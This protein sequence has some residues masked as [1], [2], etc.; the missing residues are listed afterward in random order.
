MPCVHA[1]MC[2][3][4]LHCFSGH[5]QQEGLKILKLS[6]VLG[7]MG[8]KAEKP[9]SP[10]ALGERTSEKTSG[11]PSLWHQ[12]PTAENL[13]DYWTKHKTGRHWALLA[14]QLVAWFGALP[15]VSLCL[16]CAWNSAVLI[17]W[18]QVCSPLLP[19]SACSTGSGDSCPALSLT[20]Q[21]TFSLSTSVSSS[22]KWGLRPLW[23]TLMSTD[24]VC[25]GI[26]EPSLYFIY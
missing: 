25:C 14:L 1:R 18:G 2:S 22:L 11:T 24:E 20:C 23:D 16:H 5:R 8:N 26:Y 15:A 7:K 13:L 4:S 3:L 17:R 10:S 19:L 6:K 21:A 9:D 12:R